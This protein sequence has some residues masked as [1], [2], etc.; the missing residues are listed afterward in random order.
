MRGPGTVFSSGDDGD[1]V[2][3]DPDTGEAAAD[4]PPD[5][6]ILGE[7]QGT[8]LSVDDDGLVASEQGGI[9]V[10]DPAVGPRLE[11]R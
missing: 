11:T 8:I 3:L 10:G 7:Y 1:A 5:S 4:P 6:R 9:H 2:A